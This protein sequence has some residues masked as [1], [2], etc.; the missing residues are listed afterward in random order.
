VRGLVV[1]VVDGDTVEVVM[2]NDPPGRVYTV[3]YLGIE[4]PPNSSDNPWGVVAYETNR[5]MTNLKVVR[6]VRDQTDYDDEGHLLR[7]VYVGD[8]LMSVVLV[9][10]GLARANVVEPNIQFQAE[11]EEAETAARNSELGLWGQPPTPTSGPEQPAATDEAA[12]PEPA[13]AT[14]TVTAT[15]EA[16]TGE[17]AT[18]E[19]S[20]DESETTTPTS[21][22]SSEVEV[23]P[24][25]DQ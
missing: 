1:R 4:T 9:E 19:A 16:G 22:G 5:E 10:E 14:V 17:P 21:E 15:E 20:P 7:Y 6:L 23:T 24:P 2:E 25:S 3:D 8:E 11:I 12:T 18:E 13:A